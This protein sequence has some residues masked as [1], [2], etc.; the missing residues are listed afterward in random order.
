MTKAIPFRKA[1][2][3]L[4][5]V[6]TLQVVAKAQK[7]EMKS[8][9]TIPGSKEG[10]VSLEWGSGETIS[11]QGVTV[12]FELMVDDKGI[13]SGYRFEES[14]FK[15]LKAGD[16]IAFF[17][18][19]LEYSSSGMGAA[20]DKS[21]DKLWKTISYP[22]LKG[23][24]KTITIE[25]ITPSGDEVRIDVGEELN[26]EGGKSVKQL[27]LTSKD[28]YLIDTPATGTASGDDETAKGASESVASNAGAASATKGGIP[29]WGWMAGIAALLG[30]AAL[31]LIWMRKGVKREETREIE[32]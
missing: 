21:G 28:G 9:R 30:L 31:A 23:A 24:W 16:R 20:R 2:I 8:M 12:K 29:L 7:I 32:S 26:L 18:K 14:G 15:S 4:A 27:K 19:G 1:M 10:F 5:L 11:K 6:S 25:S 22:S 13:P 17:I 3:L